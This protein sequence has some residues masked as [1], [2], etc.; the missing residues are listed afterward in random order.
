MRR[1]MFTKIC[2]ICVTVL[3]TDTVEEML[4]KITMATQVFEDETRIFF[5]FFKLSIRRNATIFIT[6]RCIPVLG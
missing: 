3:V 2:V 6:F 1:V 5:C 4:Q